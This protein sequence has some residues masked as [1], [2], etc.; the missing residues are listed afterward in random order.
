MATRTVNNQNDAESL[1]HFLSFV[2]D[3]KDGKYTDHK[4]DIVEIT[5]HRLS[6]DEQMAMNP[7]SENHTDICLFG[8][9]Y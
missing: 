6:D 4:P 8:L 5:Y 2:R 9:T 3:T 7:L 1:T